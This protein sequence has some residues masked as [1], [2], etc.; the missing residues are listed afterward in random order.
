MNLTKNNIVIILF[1]LT[2]IYFFFFYE[3]FSSNLRC[4]TN[5]EGVNWELINDTC[6]LNCVSSNKKT[7][8][9]K[10]QVGNKWCTGKQTA[11]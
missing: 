4:P 5:S 8:S 9:T 6:G 3:K 10:I 2:I 1:G 11:T 7:K